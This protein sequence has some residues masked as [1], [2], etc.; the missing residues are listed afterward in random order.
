MNSLLYLLY[1]FL[2]ELSKR[3]KKQSEDMM[4]MLNKTLAKLNNVTTESEVKVS[5]FFLIQ[6]TLSVGKPLAR[7]INCRLLNFSSASI[8]KVLQCGSKLVKMKSESQTAWIWV[9]RR[10]T[11]RLIWIQAVCI[12]DYSRAWRSKG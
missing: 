5:I 12:W 10:V 3:Y 11:R 1:R 7:Q 8:F 4:K 6:L 2:E 9:R